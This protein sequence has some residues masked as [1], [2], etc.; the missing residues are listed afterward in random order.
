MNQKGNSDKLAANT[1][2]KDVDNSEALDPAIESL[3]YDYVGFFPRLGARVIDIILFLILNLILLTLVVTPIVQIQQSLNPDCKFQFNGKG[4]DYELCKSVTN[5][6]QVATVSTSILSF[7]LVQAYFILTS[8]S[9]WQATLGKKVFK[10][11]VVNQEFKKVSLLQAFARE[12]FW[13]VQGLLSIVGAFF[14]SQIAIVYSLLLL[15]IVV[16]GIKIFFSAKRQAIHDQV[17]DTY[18]VKLNEEI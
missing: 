7:L 5:Y 2:T 12:S 14:Y 16:D 17:A 9:R 3:G 8:V 6:N 10:L 11:K 4:E 15:F 18:V 13:I 1:S